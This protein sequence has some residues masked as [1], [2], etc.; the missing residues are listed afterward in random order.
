MIGACAGGSS[1]GATVQIDG[2]DRNAAALID[3]A[4]ASLPEDPRA[5]VR[6]LVNALMSA[7]SDDSAAGAVGELLRRAGF[8]IVTADGDVVALP[9]DAGFPELPIYAELLPD[10]A[11]SVRTQT[12]Y[13]FSTVASH[14]AQAGVFPEAPDWPTVATML[15][16][17]GKDADAPPV[18]M[19]ASSAIRGLAGSHGQPFDATRNPDDVFFDVVQLMVLYAHL[20]S[21]PVA[22]SGSGGGGGGLTPQGGRGTC[23]QIL[24][25]FLLENQTDAE[26]VVHWAA[27]VVG[28]A[29]ADEI[30]EGLPELLRVRTTLLRAAQ[31]HFGT[32][33]S[34][35]TL[36]MMMTGVKLRAPRVQEM[37]YM[38]SDNETAAHRTL[39]V[40]ATFESGL[41]RRTIK[42]F[43][44][45]GVDVPVDGPL[46]GYTV[47]W[48]IATEAAG[49]IRDEYGRFTSTGRHVR[50]VSSPVQRY[51][52][53][54][55]DR[56]GRARL[57][58]KPP[59]EGEPAGSGTLQYDMV[60]IKASLR[61]EADVLGLVLGLLTPGSPT[62]W[63]MSNLGNLAKEI[64]ADLVLPTRRLR[65]VVSW[66]GS[67][68]VVA[69]GSL[70]NVYVLPVGKIRSVSV[71]LTS[72]D[73]LRGPFRGDA[74][75]GGMEVNPFFVG[76]STAGAALAGQ[77][78]E[79]E[80]TL[81]SIGM[82]LRHRV[83]D[84]RP[85]P[86]EDSIFE[87]FGRQVDLQGVF[88]LKPDFQN[89]GRN[90]RVLRDGRLGFEVGKLDVVMN[91]DGTPAG[92]SFTMATFPVHRVERDDRCPAEPP[93]WDGS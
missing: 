43:N 36:W 77:S 52:K 31:G 87:L 14:L 44:L 69:K 48:S 67:D 6:S 62:S 3:E 63:L 74:T 93:H 58:I 86:G 13:P 11:E 17:W 45:A 38:H 37:H 24:R 40:T 59:V 60:V 26:R 64:G 8:P 25:F 61:K 92:W 1:G 89:H 71:D 68:P 22:R 5:A 82:G 20:G 27:D 57:T 91:S 53:V 80:A 55:T 84:V 50:V 2:V 65:V 79:F 51:P 42:C 35:V 78:G 72:C 9:D 76:V 46:E 75:W 56:F 49:P 70:K 73:G 33:T 23:E 81:D 7:E 29:I 15:S 90:F 54:T 83:D 4:G 85:V 10:I 18:V 47:E 34:L 41:S 21:N 28:E 32:L 19:A 39:R 30:V 12:G 66:H 16:R 88:R